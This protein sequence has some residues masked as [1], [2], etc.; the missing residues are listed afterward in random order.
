M[1]KPGYEE[2]ELWGG[3]WD[4]SLETVRTDVDLIEMPWF[5]NGRWVTER[6]R[7]A[8]RC[9]EIN[10]RRVSYFVLRFEGLTV[11]P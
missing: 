11:G 4:G 5:T 6:Y 7:R 8:R 2:L 1:T 10:G 3:P 9:R